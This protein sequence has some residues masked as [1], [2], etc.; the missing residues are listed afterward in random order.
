MPLRVVWWRM[1]ALVHVVRLS[2]VGWCPRS[3]AAWASALLH[4]QPA[5]SAVLGCIVAA[6]VSSAHAQEFQT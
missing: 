4:W 5:P 6:C 3:V 2:L 1:V